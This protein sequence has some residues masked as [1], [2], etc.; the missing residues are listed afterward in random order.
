MMDVVISLTLPRVSLAR[1]R[2]RRSTRS[3]LDG[4]TT[5][6]VTLA[7][8]DATQ[9]RVYP[10]RRNVF[11]IH[12]CHLPFSSRSHHRTEIVPSGFVLT[13]PFWSSPYRNCAGPTSVRVSSDTRPS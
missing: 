1:R 4:L 11:V 2:K 6:V 5:T 8:R 9:R 7:S 3:R 13:A 12:G 10:R